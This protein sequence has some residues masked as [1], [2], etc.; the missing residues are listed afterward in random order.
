MLTLFLTLLLAGQPATAPA[1]A[2]PAPATLPHVEF[3]LP[4]PLMLSPAAVDRLAERVRDDP[5]A[6]EAFAAI[7][8]EADAAVGVEPDP[9]A[10]IIYEGRV[11][12]DPDRVRTARHLEDMRRLRALSW[13]HALTGE[14]QYLDAARRFLSAWVGTV[15][16]SGNDVNDNKLVPIALALH[17][18]GED[19]PEGERKAARAW[20][21]ELEARHLSRLRELRGNRGAKRLKVAVLAGLAAGDPA[22]A[23]K[24]AHEVRA[25]VATSL[26][27]DGTSFDLEQRDAMHYHAGG[28]N[29]PL[30]ILANARAAGHDVGDAYRQ[31]VA[32][33]PNAGASLE[34]SVAYM[35]PYARGE[36]IYPEWVNTKIELDRRRAATGDPYYQPGKPWDPAEAAD[37]LLLASAFDSSLRPLARDLN[38]REGAEEQADFRW[39][40]LQL[41]AADEE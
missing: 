13:A 21:W 6:A 16:I 34:K 41:D 15:R 27:P 30:Q 36:K 14:P 11:S 38:A 25:Y 12:N 9:I 23:G 7:R 22:I 1:P 35:L 3:D 5:A 40:A 10:E 2:A 17:L 31:P 20:A 19:L 33:G 4:T 26:R 18:L 39:L 28:M 32:D 8:A 37:V 29:I 24:A